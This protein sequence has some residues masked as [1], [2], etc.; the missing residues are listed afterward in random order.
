MSQSAWKACLD[1]YALISISIRRRWSLSPDYVSQSAGL[2][3]CL[4]LCLFRYSKDRNWKLALAPASA[5]VLLFILTIGLGGVMLRGSRSGQ[6]LHSPSLS[7]CVCVTRPHVCRQC[8]VQY[9]LCPHLFSCSVL[10]VLWSNE[11]SRESSMGICSQESSSFP[12]CTT[13]PLYFFLNSLPLSF[14]STV[15]TV[16][17]SSSWSSFLFFSRNKARFSRDWDRERRRCDILL[18][19]AHIVLMGTSSDTCCLMMVPSF[20]QICCWVWAGALVI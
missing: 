6:I 8:S 9:Q 3:L 12:L 1:W 19:S 2:S 14:P 11:P 7:Q 20:K 17:S 13:W 16:S 4:C 18:L 15:A 5:P 10:V